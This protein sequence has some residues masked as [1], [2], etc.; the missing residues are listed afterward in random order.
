MGKT[1][2][3]RWKEAHPGWENDAKTVK[4]VICA[5]QPCGSGCHNCE[6]HSVCFNDCSIEEWMNDE[7]VTIQVNKKLFLGI[8]RRQMDAVVNQ[9]A[10][11]DEAIED[12]Y[13]VISKREVKNE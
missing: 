2:W 5:F 8:I 4:K 7:R 9:R 10:T 1:N 12:L 3:E 6:L 11:V 13:T